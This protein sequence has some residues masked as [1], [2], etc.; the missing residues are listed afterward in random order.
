MFAL[1]TSA[2]GAVD[3]YKLKNLVEVFE[4]SGDLLNA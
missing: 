4:L 3:D 1:Q 2:I